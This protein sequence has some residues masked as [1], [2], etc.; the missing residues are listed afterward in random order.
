M[1]DTVT[2]KNTNNTGQA[3]AGILFGNLHYYANPDQQVL[4]LSKDN[5]GLQKEIA[6]LKE[7][8]ELLKQQNSVLQDLIKK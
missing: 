6:F 1:P 4:H 3:G 8:L 5:E 7:Q 2:L